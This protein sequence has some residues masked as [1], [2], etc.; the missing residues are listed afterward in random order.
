MASPSIVKNINDAMSAEIGTTLG[1]DY[2]QLP[3][4]YDVV[5]NNFRQSK[6]RYGVRPLPS[7]EIDGVVKVTTHIQT[8][9]VVLTEGFT[10]TSISDTKLQDKVF[11]AYE[12]MHT[13]YKQ[14]VN[15]K[16]G[17]PLQVLDVSGLAMS[18]PEILEEDKVVILRATIDVMYRVEL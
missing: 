7:T 16:A 14:V 3:Y 10:D 9:E 6:R 4:I 13:L 1:L 15:V 2:A 5:K 18:E 12:N 8:F 11:I 17:V